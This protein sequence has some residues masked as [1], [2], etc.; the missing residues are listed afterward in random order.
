MRWSG[1]FDVNNVVS[2]VAMLRSVAY[3]QTMS[4]NIIARSFYD[5]I[6]ETRRNR[7]LRNGNFAVAVN[8]S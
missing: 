7:S 5:D 3:P 4:I 1:I 8:F 2:R 6:N